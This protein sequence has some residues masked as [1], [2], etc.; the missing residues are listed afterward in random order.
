MA[1]LAFLPAR[2]L[3]AGPEPNG[4][5]S[6]R[7]SATWAFAALALTACNKGEKKETLTV[8]GSDTMVILAQ[9][10]AE[11]YMRAHP[12]LTIQVTGG[13]SGTGIA[14]L[15]NGTTDLANLSRP[16]KDAEKKQLA[17]KYGSNGVE[18]KVARDGL[19][20]FLHKA[21]PVESLTI[22]QIKA[23]YQGKITNWKEVGGSDRN[24]ITYGRENNSGTYEYFKEHV[25]DKE[26]FAAN[27]QSL[28]GTAG[29]VNAVS[30]DEGGI[31][32]GGAAYGEGI[33]MALVK[34]DSASPAKSPTQENVVSGEY[35]ISRNLFIYMRQRPEGKTK[36]FIDW[37]LADAGQTLVADAG[38][39]P[40]RALTSATVAAP[41]P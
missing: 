28:P 29:V 35:P 22:A 21:N 32:F 37:I 36:E 6:M 20:I 2:P 27:V 19:S 1:E 15:I 10:W 40:I 16:I 41:A 14:A 17:E 3:R 39:F 31:G 23:M 7:I 13:G 33:K 8:K 30:K 12:D 25:L 11:A 26:D 4:E 34:A 18:I 24:I 9:Q 38:Y 5:A